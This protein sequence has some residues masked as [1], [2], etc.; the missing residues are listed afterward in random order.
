[1]KLG[2]LRLCLVILLL[3]LGLGIALAQDSDPA[4]VM[5]SANALYEEGRFAEAAAVYEQLV[6]Q[7]IRDSAVYYNLGNAYFKQGIVGHAILNYRIAQR[8]DPRDEDVQSN[9]E[10]ARLQTVDQIDSGGEDLLTQ[11]TRVAQGWLSINEMAIAVLALWFL[12][13]FLFI[14]WLFLRRSQREGARALI[15]YALLLSVFLL[16]GG[17]FSFGGRIYL[18]NVRPQGVVLVDEIE[19]MS[20]PGDQYIAEFTLHNG[21]EVSMIE[22]RNNWVRI[23]LPG[24]QFQGWVPSE[25]VGMVISY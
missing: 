21:A 14:I 10:L 1:M 25:T 23:T 22:G 7:N 6:N 11:L 16:I 2:I 8:L 15:L 5:E 19:V 17:M 4:A 24:G 12:T 18:E 20:G 13:V 3:S 9:L